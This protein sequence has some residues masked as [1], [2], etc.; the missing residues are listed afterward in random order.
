MALS[1]VAMT[2]SAYFYVAYCGFVDYDDSA[3]V[4]S[5]KLVQQGL[6]WHGL[7]YAFTH[8]ALFLYTPVT[9]LSHMLDCQLFGLDPAGAHLMSLFYHLLCTLLIFF[10][11]EKM[12]HEPWPSWAVAALFGLHPMHVEAVAWI[13]ERKEVL[14]TLFGLLA[15]LAYA[16]YAESRSKRAY[17]LVFV[18][19]LLS[20]LAKPMLVTL[21]FLLLLL[22]LWPLG[23][24]DL[25]ETWPPREDGKAPPWPNRLK[26]GWQKEAWPLLKEK[27]PLFLLVFAFSVGT[28]LTNK[29]GG[30]LIGDAHLP[31]A[32]K[33]ENIFYAY[34]QYIAKLFFPVGLS[35]FY[36][37]PDLR[38]TPLAVLP[39]LLLLLAVTLLALRLADRAPYLLVGWL[40]FLGTLVPVIG[41]I[42]VGAMQ[43]YADRYTYF[44][45]TG[46][47]IALVWP[48]YRWVKGRGLRARIALYLFSL[49]LA[50]LGI[51]TAFQ[52][53]VWRN[54]ET[55][56]IHSLEVAPQ[57]NYVALGSLG[58]ELYNK[59]KNLQGA[60]ELL[61]RSFAIAVTSTSLQNY[62]M[63]MT[64]EGDFPRAEAFFRR[65][66]AMHVRNDEQLFTNLAFACVHEGKYT[67]ALAF[68]RRALTL[69]PQ[70]DRAAHNEVDALLG[71]GRLQ[72]AEKRAREGLIRNPSSRPWMVRLAAALWGEGRGGE[73]KRWVQRALA[74][75]HGSVVVLFEAVQEMLLLPHPS[76]QVRQETL[77][78]AGQAYQFTG[79]RQPWYA[80]IL[81]RAL[82]AAGQD[83]QAEKVFQT[84]LAQARSRRITGLEKMVQGELKGLASGKKEEK[85]KT[86]D[87]MPDKLK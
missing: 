41:L 85:R 16:F 87:G 59:Y 86:R 28:Y 52:T 83:Q 44:T 63:L 19:L 53:A 33:T 73:A 74:E 47:F 55:L 67:E 11:L 1:L 62:G 40:W 54:T 43:A 6:S 65:A 71:L 42:H 39:P 75:S 2:A 27:I 9:L 66:L 61:E 48:A 84:C 79:G 30:T 38:S 24:L 10:L 77:A 18:C 45:Y 37:L 58:M 36:P 80:F 46:A 76:P 23:R 14:S 68:A 78:M 72:E 5:N 60:K 3:Y 82:K 7:I 26:A 56:F 64:R 35:V 32:L 12:T 21:P 25:F 49:L 31:L 70:D 13:A 69:S 17:W 15:L 4:T 81:G 8:T 22:D 34:G 29:L 51:Q 50:A 57:G 20:L